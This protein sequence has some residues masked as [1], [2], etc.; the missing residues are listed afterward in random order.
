MGQSRGACSNHNQAK[1]LSRIPQIPRSLQVWHC[2]PSPYLSFLA[3]VLCTMRQQI[4]RSVAVA[5]HRLTMT[6]LP[7][8]QRVGFVHPTNCGLVPGL[9]EPL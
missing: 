7:A 3:A 1:G 6:V 5:K 9:A 2:L 8:K 4:P